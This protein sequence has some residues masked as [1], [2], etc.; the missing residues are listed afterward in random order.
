MAPIHVLENQ[1]K[2]EDDDAAFAANHYVRWLE[3]PVD[4]MLSVQRQHTGDQLRQST[5]QSILIQSSLW[6]DIRQEIGAFDEIHG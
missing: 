3:I 5:S 6:S 1:S 2:I 4:N